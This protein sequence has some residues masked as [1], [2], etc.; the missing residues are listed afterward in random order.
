MRPDDTDE[1]TQSDGEPQ[2]PE[3]KGS[4]DRTIAFWWMC[5]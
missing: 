1:P 2:Q 4:D 3:T 5:W